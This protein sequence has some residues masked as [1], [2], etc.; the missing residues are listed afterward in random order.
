LAAAAFIAGVAAHAQAAAPGEPAPRPELAIEYNYVHSNA[1]PEDCGCINLN[2][3]SASFAWPLKHWH[4]SLVG[5]IGA[6][7]AGSI[8]SEDDDLTL[9]TYTA[10]LRYSPHMHAWHI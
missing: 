4:L 6:V 9:S 2:G 1:P 10:G 5:D 8:S 3:G 7:H